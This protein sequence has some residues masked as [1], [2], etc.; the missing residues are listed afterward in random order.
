MTVG[1]GQHEVGLAHTSRT[2][3]H[4]EPRRLQGLGQPGHLL[5]PSHQGAG[6]RRHPKHRRSVVEGAQAPDQML[7]RRPRGEAHLLLQH[8][9]AG[10]VMFEGRGHASLP[11]Q[12]FHQADV[13]IFPPGL[14]AHH[15]PQHLLRLPP[16]TSV[17]GPLY[18]CMQ[19]F[20][21]TDPQVLGFQRTPMGELGRLGNM[22]TFQEIS[23]IEVL[24]RPK[25]GRCQGLGQQAE[26]TVYV[27]FPGIAVRQHHTPAVGVQR[28]FRQ[29]PLEL[30]QRGA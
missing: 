30:I 5:F 12:G 10:L 27:R 4:H 20:Q 9:A 29:G 13:K 19:P 7:Q 24:D 28:A 2:H 16:Q 23:P 25:S 21:Q 26:Q 18:P 15:E 14:Q 6:Q 1:K 11:G 22:E 3:Q 8:R 17:K